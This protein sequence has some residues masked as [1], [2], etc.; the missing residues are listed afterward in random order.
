LGADGT[1]RPRSFRP[2]AGRAL[3]AAG[4]EGHGDLA[5]AVDG[6]QQPAV[7]AEV[8]HAL[9]RGRAPRLLQAL[10]AEPHPVGDLGGDGGA[11]EIFALAGARHRRVAVGPGAGPDDRRV[12]DPARQLAEHAGGRGRR[13]QPALGVADHAADRAG[14]QTSG[15]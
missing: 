7:A 2:A 11:D 1:P 6:D 13:R 8:G 4:G 5:V 9:D 3:E 10:A 12:A 15:G 14:G